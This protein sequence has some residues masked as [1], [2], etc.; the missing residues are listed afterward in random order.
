MSD[1]APWHELQTA[2]FSNEADVETRLVLPLLRLLGFEEADIESKKPVDFR[3]GRKGPGRKPE[4]D[5][6]V[7]GANPHNRSTSLI[8]IE[9]KHPT[10]SLKSAKEQ[11]ESYAYE[12]RTPVLILT[13][14]VELEAWQVNVAAEL[15]HIFSIKV[16]DISASRG[17]IENVLRKTSI[18][19]LARN[20][21]H[22]NFFDESSDLF[23]YENSIFENTNSSIASVHR[24]LSFKGPVSEKFKSQRFLQYLPKGAV[25]LANSGLGKTTLIDIISRMMIE[26]RWSNQPQARVPIIVP[27]QDFSLSKKTLAEFAYDR[28]EAHCPKISFAQFRDLLRKGVAFFL[29]AFD[30]IRPD[31]ARELESDLRTTLRDYPNCIVFLFT[32]PGYKLDI[33]NLPRVNL[34]PFDSLEISQFLDTRRPP[35]N[36]GLWL[37]RLADIPE[38]LK[39]LAS[40][41]LI[42][43]L[44]IEIYLSRRTLAV[45]I[46]EIYSHWLSQIME[47]VQPFTALAQHEAALSCIALKTRSEAISA[48]KAIKLL[49][50]ENLDP[51]II[52][53]LV[54]IGALVVRGQ[55]VELCHEALGDYFRA[56]HIAENSLDRIEEF[57]IFDKTTAGSQ[58][59]IILFS[60][61]ECELTKGKIWDAIVQEGIDLACASLVFSCVPSQNLP[62]IEEGTRDFLTGVLEGIEAPIN[63]HFSNLRADI[64]SKLSGS[65]GEYLQI[66]GALQDNGAWVNMEFYTTDDPK[67]PKVLKERVSQPSR[68]IGGSTTQFRKFADEGRLHGLSQIQN[69]MQI[70]LRKRELKGGPVTREEHCISRIRH[71][72]KEYN[73]PFTTNSTIIDV[74]RDLEGYKGEYVYSSDQDCL[75]RFKINDLIKDLQDMIG[76]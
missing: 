46:A 5:F 2:T 53:S 41:P 13:N 72:S 39:T 29:D 47:Q 43:N 8:T 61:V 36:S 38:N 16:S 27:L 23:L 37:F 24:T 76:Q 71:L 64:Y 50:T 34:E 6:V 4:A 33:P 1:I 40:V 45:N 74:I 35:D 66:L 48:T 18:I 57:L 32:R 49:A 65:D 15:D 55:A 17:V 22:K 30:R 44:L 63:R 62:S 11:G 51:T 42:A 56:R 31:R 12:L 52:D 69:A 10:H 28:V 21:K 3:F 9:A 59:P 7:Y 58:F 68:I 19:E 75:Q 26:D 25:V 14:G 67:A 73:F 60:I 20:L 70:L 54:Q